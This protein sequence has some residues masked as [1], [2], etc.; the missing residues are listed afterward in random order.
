MSEDDRQAQS[1]SGLPAASPGELPTGEDPREAQSKS[2]L[3]AALP[4]LLRSARPVVPPATPAVAP[5]VA[6]TVA[7]AVAPAVAPTVAP[8]PLGIKR[9]APG[10]KKAEL[11]PLPRVRDVAEGDV[12]GGG[13]S[14]ARP[15][16]PCGGWT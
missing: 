5:A 14:D 8:F 15:P 16:E 1:K 2:D 6:P 4:G 11:D 9:A 13:M 12:G 10:V 7:P 3:P